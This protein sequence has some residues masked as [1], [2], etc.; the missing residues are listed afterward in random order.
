MFPSWSR[1]NVL[2]TGAS[3]VGILLAGCA[4]ALEH[5]KT[6]SPGN[7]DESTTEDAPLTAWERSTDCDGDPDRLH[8]SVI[9]VE[10]VTE[11]LD[12]AID[13]IRFSDLSAE[14]RTI[15]R[16]VTEEGGYGTCAPSDGF[17]RFRERVA[18]RVDEQDG[19]IYL[20]RDGTYYELYVEWGD[21]IY[22]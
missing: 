13:P 22:Y 3:S 4:D 1:R 14:E 10:G 5:S 2:L 20:R 11:T 19:G 21:V 16:T 8:D 17:T 7:T 9:S 12:A 6:E 18:D 15:L